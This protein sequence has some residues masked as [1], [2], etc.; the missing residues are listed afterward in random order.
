MIVWSTIEVSCPICSH[1]T[2][3]RELGSGFGTGQDSDL[4]VR[5]AGKHII[6]AEIHTCHKCRFSGYPADFKRTISPAARRRFLEVVSPRLREPP[7]APRTTP[8]RPASAGQGKQGAGLSAT[9][10]PD[11]QYYWA[12]RSAEALA[13]PAV[14][15]GERLLRAYWCLRLPPSSYLPPDV[16][17]A[18]KKAYL[19]RAIERLREGLAFERDPSWLYLLGELCRRNGNFVLAASHLR[20]FLEHEGGARYLKLA[21]VKLLELARKRID[22]DLSMEEILYDG[23]PEPK[24]LGDGAGGM[25]ADEPGSE[26]A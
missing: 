12:Y 22:Q 15:Q 4:L 21:A 13:L 14:Q 1:R 24:P 6:Q 23:A 7:V 3:L 10:L 11:V 9:P 17:R 19:T 25:E 5:M 16:V 8:E 26:E 18:L 2:R 20:R